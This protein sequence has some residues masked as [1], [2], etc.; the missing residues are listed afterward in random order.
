MLNT[1]IQRLPLF[2]RSRLESRE[3]LQKIISNVGW[4]FIDRI[5]RMGFGLIVG[6]W[7]A[8]YLRPEQFG[9]YNY[10]IAFVGLFNPLTCLGLDSIVVRDI[11]RDPSQ[12]NE[13]L[14]TVFVLKIISACLTLLLILLIISLLRP[15]ERMIQWLVIIAGGGWVFQAFDTIDFWFQSQTQSKY[16]V[17]AKN[18]AFVISSLLKIVLIKMQAPLIAFFWLALIEV[19]IAAI[20]LVIVYRW[21]KNSFRDWRPNWLRAKKL[22]QVS[23]PLILSGVAVVIYM[24]ID[25]I[26][27]GEMLGDKAVGIYSAAVRI[28]ELWYFLP[29]AIASS[30]NPA[31]IKAKE[32]SRKHYHKRLQA[33][34]NLMVGL[35]YTVSLFIGFLSK[36]I[37]LTLF[38]NNYIESIPI[39]SVHVWSSVFVFIGVVKE[40]WLVLEG[41]TVV[42]FLS[43]FLGAIINIVLNLFLIPAY[44]GLGAAIATLV[45]YAIPGYFT[46]FLYRPMWEIGGLM[47]NALTLKWIWSRK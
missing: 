38:D 43:T 10:V 26:M 1:L 4:L 42:S 23:Y 27:L 2:L 5:V 30:V 33:T 40:Y 13:I 45:A 28:S 17:W 44:G 18:T 29:I 39:L 22:V 8:R 16:T 32:I 46:C 14:G 7:V 35:G 12:K 36:P 41:M 9:V 47:T 20:G 25:Q 24:K 15:N 31:I 3:N 11:V 6:V 21:N 37:I 34:F 19:I